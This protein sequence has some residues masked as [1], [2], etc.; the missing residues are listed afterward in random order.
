MMNE[1]RPGRRKLETPPAETP[2][3]QSK[4]PVRLNPGTGVKLWVVAWI[5]SI[6][7]SSLALVDLPI[8]D[9]LA[10]PG[11]ALA[12][13]VFVTGLAYRVGA[14]LNVWP[15]LAVGLSVVTLVF[16]FEALLAAAA[17]L[18]AVSGAVLAVMATR[19]AENSAEAIKESL[20]AV[21]VAASTM[22]AVGAWNAHV[23]SSFFNV[24]VLVAAMITSFV[25]VFS[26]GANLHGL[27][28]RYIAMLL[29]ATG[30]LAVLVVYAA[31][32]RNYGSDAL[33][34]AFESTV[35]WL[36]TT[37]IGVP[38]PVQVFL[39][40]PALVLG[41]S[42]RSQRREGWWLMVFATIGTGVMATSVVNPYAFPTYIS[43]SQLYS[44]ILG[45]ALGLV[46]RRFVVRES[47]SRAA[48]SFER[49]SRHEP[50]R[51]K[52]LK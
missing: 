33:V 18:T 29:G 26:L 11:A 28:P 31:L 10:R 1:S 23:N 4:A 42:L 40:F 7:L 12:T 32:V 24:V 45:L 8:T 47:G 20:I 13:A 48:R 25:I 34:D 50:A 41:V 43:L 5:L 9:A 22:I 30:A 52:P 6:A 27:T 16:P 2:T 49:L 44:V 39:G 15:W 17:L 14:R 35:V 36:R 19:P 46:V 38:R 21:L 37:V 3:Q 51:T